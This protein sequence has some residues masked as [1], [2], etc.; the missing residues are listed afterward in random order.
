MIGILG[1]V[2]CIMIIQISPISGANFIINDPIGD[3]AYYKDFSLVS[4]S[5]S[6]HSEIDIESFE[7]DGESVIIT[8]VEAPIA[9]DNHT[10]E[11]KIYWVGDSIVGNWTACRWSGSINFVTTRFK[12][13][14]GEI[15][16][17]DTQTGVIDPV[18]LT[19]VI[20]LFYV[21]MIPNIL[22][23][24]C[25]FVNTCFSDVFGESYKDDLENHSLHVPGFTFWITI[26]G[27]STIAM[28]GLLVTNKIYKIRNP[29]KFLL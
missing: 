10:Y 20:P 19:L 3:V 8:F 12:N 22:D 24:G 28:I 29:R 15:I 17:N 2:V 7:I 26:A 1:F 5:L 6:V 11:T 4:R 9:D 14:A 13:N 23:P 18:G 16:I 25:V 27:L 21:A